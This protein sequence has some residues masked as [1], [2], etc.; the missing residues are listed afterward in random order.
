M[1]RELKRA[2]VRKWAVKPRPGEWILPLVSLL[3]FV[4]WTVFSDIHAALTT[5]HFA[6][7]IKDFVAVLARAHATHAMTSHSIS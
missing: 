2:G 7:P 6:E 1:N 5:F 3:C 4:S